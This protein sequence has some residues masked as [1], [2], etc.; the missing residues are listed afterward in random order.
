MKIV[1]STTLI[2]SF[3]A[4]WRILLIS[5]KLIMN[6]S[7]NLFM[8]HYSAVVF[9][10]YSFLISTNDQ[11]LILPSLWRLFPVYFPEPEKIRF[12]M[13]DKEVCQLLLQMYWPVFI[14]CLNRY[15][16]RHFFDIF[17]Q[18]RKNM[19]CINSMSDV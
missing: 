9:I 5:Q 16:N 12:K 2:I 8:S 7:F 19:N 15:N 11:S 13:A 3:D 18:K 10:Y 17:A 14:F 6:N 1:H 4:F